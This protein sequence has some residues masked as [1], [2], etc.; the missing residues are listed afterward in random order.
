MFRSK[1]S[2]LL[3]FFI[4]K[5]ALGTNKSLWNCMHAEYYTHNFFFFR[6][7]VGG[8]CLLFLCATMF[9]FKKIIISHVQTLS[10]R[11]SIQTVHPNGFS[12]F[13]QFNIYIKY[14]KLIHK[15]CRIRRWLLLWWNGPMCFSS[16][17]T[18]NCI[19]PLAKVHEKLCFRIRNEIRHVFMKL[20][21]MIE[22]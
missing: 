12:D 21:K 5:D 8:E 1:F 18:P 7:E 2:R 19:L 22:I 9:F 10:K 20:R 3:F 17:F 15:H 11:V 4:E 14:S 6:K 13:H 16:S